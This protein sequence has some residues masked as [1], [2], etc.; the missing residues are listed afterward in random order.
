MTLRP[1]KKSDVP[2]LI[3][4]EQLC[5]APSDYPLGRSSFYYHLANNLM[6]VL[7]DETGRIVAYGLVLVHYA[8]AKVYS[9]CVL[10]EHRGV[11]LA[12]KL[13]LGMLSILKEKGF[14]QTELEVKVTNL[15]AIA[16]YERLGFKPVKTIGA[17]YKDGAD[18]Y[19][20][21]YHHA[22]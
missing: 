10:P 14:K 4:L 20:M 11:G 5:F 16:L 2:A 15:K 18:A 3:H 1:A 22:S 12:E 13:L 17:F 8:R 19:V 6:M 7:E 21:E 9:L